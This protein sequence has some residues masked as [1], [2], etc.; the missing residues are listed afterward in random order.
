[1]SPQKNLRVV[2]TAENLRRVIQLYNPVQAVLSAFGAPSSS[3]GRRCGD[4]SPLNRQGFDHPA[5]SSFD[6]TQSCASAKITVSSAFAIA[7]WRTI[8]RASTSAVG[9]SVTFK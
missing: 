4:E 2:R 5:D 7:N 8:L 1:M 9:I 6:K 3:K